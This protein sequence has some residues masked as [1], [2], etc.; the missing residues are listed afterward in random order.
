[1]LANSTL[2]GSHR[3]SNR[4]PITQVT[5]TLP[6][7]FERLHTAGSYYARAGQDPIIYTNEEENPAILQVAAVI[8]VACVLWLHWNVKPRERTLIV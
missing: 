5:H 4:G 8:V 2:R 6:Y 7:T 1:M 3:E